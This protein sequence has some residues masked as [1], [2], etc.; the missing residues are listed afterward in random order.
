MDFW[1]RWIVVERST[2]RSVAGPFPTK[3][4]ARRHARVLNRSLR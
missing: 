1:F 2:F 3:R 4:A